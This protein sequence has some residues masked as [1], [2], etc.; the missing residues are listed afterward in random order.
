MPERPSD[1]KAEPLP[2]GA[3]VTAPGRGAHPVPLQSAFRLPRVFSFGARGCVRMGLRSADGEG[4]QRCLG[5]ARLLSPSHATVPSAHCGRQL[6]V[7]VTK[8]T[9]KN[10]VG[11]ESSLG[12]VVSVHSQ[13]PPRLWA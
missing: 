2:P 9:G 7:T 6:S 11:Q 12:L 1:Q 13:L 5:W 3:L 10:H 8:T 4:L